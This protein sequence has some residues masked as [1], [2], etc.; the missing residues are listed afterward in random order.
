MITHPPLCL[1]AAQF[2]GGGDM[3]EDRGAGFSLGAEPQVPQH[4][5]QQ[6]TGDVDGRGAVINLGAEHSAA[7]YLFVVVQQS[8]EAGGRRC[9]YA[10]TCWIWTNQRLYAVFQIFH[11]WNLLLVFRDSHPLIFCP[12]IVFLSMFCIITLERWLSKLHSGCIINS[13]F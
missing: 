10:Y 7:G 6:D 3:C 9:F 8:E 1:P 4:L 13:E 11:F 2:L 5:P 12:D